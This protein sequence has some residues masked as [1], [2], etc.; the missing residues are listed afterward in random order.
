MMQKEAGRD[1]GLFFL[2]CGPE[3]GAIPVG[4]TEPATRK[5]PHKKNK[6][7]ARRALSGLVPPTGIEPVSGA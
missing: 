3:I 1:A 6:A 7:L 4:G 2:R 5:A